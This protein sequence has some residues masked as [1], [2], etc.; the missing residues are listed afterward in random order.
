[1]LKEEKDER[2]RH[3]E[4]SA[5]GP[6]LLLPPVFVLTF[7]QFGLSFCHVVTAAPCYQFMFVKKSK[8]VLIRLRRGGARGIKEKTKVESGSHVSAAIY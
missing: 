8:T 4:G 2:R 5:E 6:P 3:R 1:M 7:S